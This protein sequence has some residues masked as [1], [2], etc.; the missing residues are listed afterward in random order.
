MLG[1]LC[2][3]GC[4]VPKLLA[5]KWLVCG[6]RR[7]VGTSP[8]SCCLWPLK[9]VT[10]L[11]VSLLVLP[12]SLGP[13]GESQLLP[14]SRFMPLSLR[15]PPTMSPS[16][17][18]WRS[19]HRPVGVSLAL[20]H[21]R[22]LSSA[23]LPCALLHPGKDCLLWRHRVGEAWALASQPQ[24]A[25]GQVILLLEACRCISRIS[26]LIINHVGSSGVQ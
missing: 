18:A 23:Y 15:L 19:L 17:C 20:L 6:P 1:T 16:R 21:C 11:W 22:S 3:S 8:R 26:T 10:A 4:A 25:L 24:F 14:F 9:G 7:L 13:L 5:R 12:E 2:P